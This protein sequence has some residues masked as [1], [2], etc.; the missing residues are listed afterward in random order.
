MN[1]LTD[2]LLDQ[3][4]DTAETEQVH[5]HRYREARACGLSVLEATHFADSDGDLGELR[6]LIK[7]GCP[8][9]LV[10]RIVL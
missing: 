9:Q 8:M 10:R 4:G 6:R 3:A 1:E 7:L 2:D 5:R